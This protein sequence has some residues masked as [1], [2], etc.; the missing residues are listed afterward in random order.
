MERDMCVCKLESG[1][2]K[3]LFWKWRNVIG[4]EARKASQL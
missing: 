1:A 4:N 3:E 2:A